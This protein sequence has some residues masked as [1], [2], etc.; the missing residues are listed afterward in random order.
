MALFSPHGTAKGVRQATARF[1]APMVPF[2][3]PRLPD[4]FDV[5]CAATGTGRWIDDRN[6]AYDFGREL[7]AGVQCTFTV[8]GTLVDVAGQPVAAA[9]F[10]FSTGGPAV[11]GSVPVEG[12][13]AIDEAQAFLLALDAPATEQSVLEHA[14]CNV[15]GIGER[16]GVKLVQG[17]DR[18]TVLEANRAFAEEHLR[19]YYRPGGRAY[20]KRDWTAAGNAATLP[21]AVV[22]CQRP[23]PND[24]QVRLV[25]GRGIAAASGIATA[26]DQTLAFR[27][28]AAFRARLTCTRAAK[29]AQCIPVLPI[30]LTFNAPIARAV[31]EKVI[32]RGADGKTYAATVDQDVSFVQRVV[33]DGPF[34]EKASFRIELPPG[35]EDDAGRM[36]VNAASFPLTVKTDENPPLAKFAARFGIVEA[37]AGAALPVTVRNIAAA[38]TPGTPTIDGRVL[39][40]DAASPAAVADWLRRLA[41]LER[42]EWRYDPKTRTNVPVRR[43]GERSIFAP[44]D[45]T[46]NLRVPAA[47]STRSTEVIGIPLQRTGFYVVELASPRLG[48]A[49]LGKPQPYYAQAAALVTNLSVHL[50]LGRESS[51]VWVTRLD[52]GLPVAGAEVTVADCKGRSHFA[53]RTSAEGLLR[54]PKALP[55]RDTLPDCTATGDKQYLVTA[56]LGD[57]VGFVLSSWNEGITPWRFNL[58]TGAWDGPYIAT[59]V[60]DRTLLRAGETVH[61]KHFVRRHAERGVEFV[62]AEALEDRIVIRHGGSDDRFELPVQWDAHGIAEST[63]AIP[64]EAKQG[65]YTVSVL[66]RFDA[67]SAKDAPRERDA[68]SFRVESFRVPTMKAVLV[69]PKTALVRAESATVDA[70]VSYLAGGAAALLPVRVRGLVEPKSVRFADFDSFTIANGDVK[71]G[72]E[73]P[74][75]AYAEEDEA[76]EPEAPPAAGQRLLPARAFTLD[77]AGGGRFTL[78]GLPQYDTPQALI[79]ELEYPDP[80][81]ERLTASTTIPL[82]PA[83][84]LPGL[85]LDDWAAARDRLAF[86]ALAVDV[87]GKPVAGQTIRVDLLTRSYFTH[88]KRLVG[89]FYA[90]D[91]VV[92]VKRIGTVCEG[93][94]D[95]FGRLHCEVKPVVSGNVVLRAEVKDDAGNVAFANRD[96]WVAGKGDWWFDQKD[97]DRMDVLPERKRY[98]PGDVARLQVRMPFREA[99]ALV[100]VEREGVLDGFVTKLDGQSPV[101]DVPVKGEHAPN[102]YVSVL[103]VRGR[104][105]DIQ[106]TAM[107]DLGK[108]AFRLGIAEIGVG[109]RAHEIKVAVQ[110]EREVYRVRDKAIVKVSAARADGG[111]LPAGAQIALAAV[112]EGLLSL[113]PNQSWNLLEA[114][115]RKRGIEVETSTAQMEVIGK[116]HYGRKALPTGGGGGRMN[117]RELFET[118]LVWRGRVQLDERGEARV[119]VPLNDSLTSF[120][121]VAIADAD[122]SL[123]GA[124]EARIRTTQDVMLVSGLPPIVREGDRVASG[125]TVRNATDKALS[126][127][128]TPTLRA[129]DGAGNALPA[130]KLKAERLNLAPGEARE[131]N[132]DIA[133]PGGAARLEWE[134]TAVDPRVAGATDAIRINQ[135]VVPAVPVATLQGTIA[136]LDPSLRMP[137]AAPQAALP[138]RGGVQVTLAPRIAGDLPGVR[139]FMSAYP[140]TCLEQRASQA[141]ALS[142]ATRWQQV[143]DALP[144][145]LDSDGLAKFFAGMGQ[146]S[147]VLTAY[148]LSISHEAGKVLPDAARERMLDG[149]L[150]FASGRLQRP[151]DIGAADLTLRKLA[152]LDALS[153]YRKDL[154]PRLLDSIAVEPNLW[155]TSS[156]LDWVSLLTRL[157]GLPEREQRLLEARRILRSRLTLRGTLLVLSAERRDMMWWLMVSPDVNANRTLIAMLDDPEARPDIARLARGALARQR[158]GHWDTTPANAWGV[159][160]LDRFSGRFDS[161]P[162]TGTTSAALANETK[163]VDWSGT[164]DG[165]TLA[166]AWPKTASE[167]AIAQAGS[168]K[169][170]ATVLS[171]AAVPLRAP[172]ASGYRIARTMTSVEQKTPGVW[173]R[174]DLARVRLELEADQDMTWVVVSDPVPA[175]ATALGSGLGGDSRIAAGATTRSGS[176]SIAFTERMFDAFRVYYDYVPQGRWSLEYLVRLNSAGRFELP[177]TRV[178]ALY[179]PEMF[180]ALPNPSVEV[181]P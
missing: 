89:G 181:R 31:A 6:W 1:S 42:T 130:P 93:R 158:R 91:N 131:L 108:P 152:A 125:F 142:D 39:R 168:G 146:G 170:W 49:L 163:S 63:W 37:S 109:Y 40:V 23:L 90:Y 56:K 154:S 176:A 54:I 118:L 145:H 20:R 102:V 8:K 27:T 24:A 44:G 159:V 117:V 92:D 17:A 120:R 13:R 113:W 22:Q 47:A 36:L 15:D 98:E 157:Q 124:G 151:S 74:G 147:D 111:T 132:W 26:G 14:W 178:E 127:D 62:R 175:G 104:V 64:K 10:E 72:V 99:T 97:G 153:R 95:R 101:V 122:A 173:S 18:A 106:P 148:L 136:Q 138:N 65:T 172:L 134:A 166:F 107:V 50:K 83:R 123:F 96:A 53:G 165:A 179:A 25:W 57:D 41:T 115:M 140:F 116:R 160:A 52:R 137:I 103:A 79:A 119:E 126:L 48:A 7:P 16:I 84:V 144:S 30:A 85:K 32:L 76:P 35:L 143:M 45:R 59:T 128:V 80:N 112:D 2:G 156:L 58:E 139:E 94:T 174:G 87:Q 100:T 149:L 9:T 105:S 67:A 86:D 110:P 29:Q 155:P 34:P 78:D 55:R 11:I 135:Q 43:V 171:R 33:F 169:P 114:M 68:G 81:G 77:K 71:E 75:E 4:P 51:L 141:I 133:V 5:K 21:I 46:T 38:T 28:R 129:V 88:R 121:I 177:P 73:A 150:A 162:V 180:A 70:Q 60:F 19:R 164:K 3:E 82:W 66:E 12:A 167:L 61:M 161:E 69:P